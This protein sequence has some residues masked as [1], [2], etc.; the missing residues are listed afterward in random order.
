M[1][2]ST[3]HA[4]LAATGLDQWQFFMCHHSI[5]TFADSIAIEEKVLR[6]S[7][8]LAVESHNSLLEH[9]CET[10]DELEPEWR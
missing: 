8:G 4:C 3:S 6:D 9:T 2:F 5:L 1:P 7:T 10:F